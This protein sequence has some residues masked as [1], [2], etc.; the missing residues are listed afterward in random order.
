LIAAGKRLDA[1]RVF[2]INTFTAQPDFAEDRIRLDAVSA[3]SEAQ[4]I[5]LTRRLSDRFLPMLVQ[6]VERD[7]R[8]GGPKDIGLAMSQQQLRIERAEN[9]LPDVDPGQNAQRWLCRTIHLTQH[10]D[11]LEW[12]LTDDADLIARMFLPGTGP[13]AV[14]DIFLL[15]Y[16]HLEWGLEVFPEWLKDEGQ[17]PA[18]ERVTLN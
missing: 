16:R 2:D 8:P 15:M 6:Q 4:S 1:N 11:A 12:T 9:P 3:E 10:P 17:A 18:G 7:V 5:F 13:R 14:L